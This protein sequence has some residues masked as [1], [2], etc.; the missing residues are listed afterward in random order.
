[1]KVPSRKMTIKEKQQTRAHMRASNLDPMSFEPMAFKQY[2]VEHGIMT[3]EDYDRDRDQDH[4]GSHTGGTA[5]DGDSTDNDESGTV[6]VEGDDEYMVPD[7]EGAGSSDG[8]SDASTGQADSDEQSDESQEGETGDETGDGTGDS[9]SE[10]EADSGQQSDSDDDDFGQD[11]SNDDEPEREQTAPPEA[12]SPMEQVIYDIVWRVVNWHHDNHDHIDEK[13]IKKIVELTAREHG[14]D[15]EQTEEAGEEFKR[16]QFK[17]GDRKFEHKCLPLIKTSIAAGVHPFLIG[18]AASGK[19]TAAEHIAEDMGL[20][21]YMIGKVDDVFMLTGYKNAAGDYVPTDFFKCFTEGG[22]FLFDE[23]DRYS[24]A[25]FII[26]NA[27]LSNGYMAF[28][29]GRFHKHPDCIVI[30]AGNTA[31]HGASRRYSASQNLD[32]STKNRFA[33]FDFPYDLDLERNIA[34]DINSKCGKWVDWVQATRAK[35]EQLNLEVL[36]TPRTTENGAK[37][38]AAGMKLSDVKDALVFT[39]IPK[40]T[41]RQLGKRAAA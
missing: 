8:H 35:V 30:G 31:A 28:P 16:R 41:A 9:D 40:D 6:E 15:D 26:V 17:K 4:R 23:M 39:G 34:L 10:S 38:L 32:G 18:E 37:L 7:N 5:R 22:V 12:E 24:S 14:F 11:R 19:T 21:F 20:P 1:M 13:Q 36:V 29:H 3:G 25:A 27:A 33:N 2:A